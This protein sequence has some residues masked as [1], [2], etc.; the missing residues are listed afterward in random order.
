MVLIGM[1]HRRSDPLKVNRAYAYSVVA[2]AEG[3]DFF[4][5]TPGKVNIKKRTILGKIYEKG[6]WV[7]KSFPFP[8][9]IYN[10]SYPGTEKAEEIV[11]YLYERIPFTSHSVGDK[12]GVYQRI[13][14]GE[15]FK[16]YLIPTEEIKEI[17]QVYEMLDRFPEVIIKPLSGSQGGGIVLIKKA[18]SG[19]FD[20]T[21][22]G[23]DHSLT[24]EELSI[25]LTDRIKEMEYLV[26]PFM[27]FK[28]KEGQV[29]DFRLHVQK[30]GK[31]NWTITTIYPRVGY[32]GSITANLGSGGYTCYLDGFLQ[33]QFQDTWYDMKRTLEIFALSFAAHFDTLYD[34][35][36]DELG[37]D[38]GV[39]GDERLWLIEVNW[40]PGPPVAFNCELDVARNLVHYAKYLAESNKKHR[41]KGSQKNKK[42]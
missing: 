1:L 35:S 25:L 6:E 34:D 7:E 41:K 18:E 38:V 3:V 27:A 37:I 10:A 19:D 28:M 2:K 4:Y 12:L 31:G 23:T 42:G 5:F 8:D 22:S 16:S 21:E 32:I 39:D 15:E 17:N 26:Q 9:V 20:I 14:R 40:R 11:D 29:Y 30:D 36:F 33:K 24:K 13:E